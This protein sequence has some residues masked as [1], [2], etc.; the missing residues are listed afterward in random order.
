[1]FCVDFFLATG[2]TRVKTKCK[3][4]LNVIF[5]SWGKDIQL[6]SGIQISILDTSCF[7]V[8]QILS[9]L[10]G[11]HRLLKTCVIIAPIMG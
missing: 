3:F 10:D 8:K 7:I 1:M 9:F 2:V 11:V 5:V 4:I 6:S